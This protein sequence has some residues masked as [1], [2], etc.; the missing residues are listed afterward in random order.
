MGT[1][2]LQEVV[3]ICGL[4]EEYKLQGREIIGKYLKS[5]IQEIYNGAG[6]DSWIELGREVLTILMSLFK[7]A[8]LIHDLDFDNSD[9][10]EETFQ[11]V[12]DRWKANCRAVLDANY[13]L[14][15]WKQ[16]M[17]EYRRERAY[18]YG[19]MVLGNKAVSGDSARAAWKAACNR[20][21]AGR[22]EE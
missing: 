14:L 15:T 6:P 19:V 3:R 13:P 18:W 11:K 16:L 7:P 2:T 1:Y 22:K 4:V 8:I 10:T 5:E 21:N 9:G 20:K 17:P 12:T